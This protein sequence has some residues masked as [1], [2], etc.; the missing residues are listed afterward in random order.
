MAKMDNILA[1][2][3][4]VFKGALSPEYLVHY[5]GKQKKDTDYPVHKHDFW[6]LDLIVSGSLDV[7]LPQGRRASQ[8]GMFM[9]VPPELPHGFHFHEDTAITTIRFSLTGVQA[10]FAAGVVEKTDATTSLIFSSLAAITASASLCREEKILLEN[11]IKAAVEIHCLNIGRSEGIPPSPYLQKA[12]EFIA[13][14]PG[15][16]LTVSDVAARA[17]CA[18]PYLSSLF[19]RDRGLSLKKHIDL[20]KM[21]LI[22]RHLLYS[23][24]S[25][26]EIA[27]RTGFP[28]IY[29]FSR[30]VKRES[31]ESPRALR[32]LAASRHV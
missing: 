3:K 8:N 25:I 4:I 10:S 23:D 14:E 29:S 11:I 15:R 6:H 21:E 17:G 31:G 2:S 30:F 18:P 26:T 19:R 24:L 9:I 1:K 22:R 32:N 28:D 27:E 16:R 12:E 20:R 5:H 7:D 13:A